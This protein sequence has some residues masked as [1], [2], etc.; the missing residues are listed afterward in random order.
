MMDAARSLL[1]R[2]IQPQWSL[3]ARQPA[4]VRTAG[5]PVWQDDFD[6]VAEMPRTFALPVRGRLAGLLG[7]QA[8]E[9]WLDTSLEAVRQ[10]L[11]S[12]F[13][14]KARL[15]LA[16]PEEPFSLQRMQAWGWLV[17]RLPNGMQVPTADDI[18]EY[19]QADTALVW[20]QTPSLASGRGVTLQ[21]VEA[22]CAHL[23]DFSL[24]L[25][26]F[27][28]M[29][30]E[31]WPRWHGLK[32]RHPNLLLLGGFAHGWNLP[33]LGMVYLR[34]DTGLI[35]LLEGVWPEVQTGHG[36]AQT[37]MDW[38]TRDHYRRVCLHGQR[39]RQ[40]AQ[41]WV[42]RW[43]SLPTVEIVHAAQAPFIYL[44]AVRP[45][46][47]RSKLAAGGQGWFEPP[48]PMTG[49]PGWLALSMEDETLLQQVD[50]WLRDGP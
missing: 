22:L 31:D 39:I 5:G 37:A 12:M 8:D 3:L 43:R 18:L 4:P 42:E 15:L 34:A 7:G 1:Q 20:L 27:S 30:P 26:D 38:I 21:E 33:G 14:A 9:Y 23:R 48:E 45:A 17:D 29:P 40:R 36:Q 16:G 2:L 50:R 6:R 35:R 32:E 13:K 25:V 11:M 10:R 24:V 44:R 19:W 49:Q 47:L 46:A 28:L 41:D